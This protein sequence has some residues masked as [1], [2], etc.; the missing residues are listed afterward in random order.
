MCHK[1]RETANR[2]PRQPLGGRQL[3]AVTSTSARQ[4]NSPASAGTREK[5]SLGEELAWVEHISG[6]FGE[7]CEAAFSGADVVVAGHGTLGKLAARRPLMSMAVVKLTIHGLSLHARSGRA[8]HS[9]A[10][11][12]E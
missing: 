3:P 10:N 1:R 12:R 11:A 6:V 9:A 8:S 2:C 4:S 7:A 5:S